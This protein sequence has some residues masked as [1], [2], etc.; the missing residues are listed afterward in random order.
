MAD[1]FQE[2]VVTFTTENGETFVLPEDPQALCY[3]KLP[4]SLKKKPERLLRILNMF[5][6]SSQNFQD[7]LHESLEEASTEKLAFVSH[8][9][10]GACGNLALRD[11]YEKLQKMESDAKANH[12]PDPAFID[13]F[14]ASYQLAF[15]EIQK[16]IV[17]NQH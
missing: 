15:Q 9:Y 10:K 6:E 2:K 16:T 3:D 17:L 14:Q 1:D 7:Q 4:R 12:L 13:A 8:S 11:L 5:V